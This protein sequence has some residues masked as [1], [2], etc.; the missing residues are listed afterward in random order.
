MMKKRKMVALLASVASICCVAAGM[1]FIYASAEEVEETVTA[2]TIEDVISEESGSFAMAYGAAV[3]G[4]ETNKEKNG[5]KYT[6]TMSEAHYNGLQKSVEDGVYEDVS[7]G[8]FILPASM[9]ETYA[10]RDYAFGETAKYNWAIKNAETGAWEYTAEEGKSRITNLPGTGMIYDSRFE[11]MAFYGITTNILPTNLGREML[12]VGYIAYTVNGV[13]DYVFTPVENE[14]DNVRSMAFVAQAAIEDEAENADWLYTTYVKPVEESELTYSYKK[15]YY[16]QNFAGAYILDESKTETAYASMNEIVSIEDSFVGYELDE[17]QK[18]SVTTA[19]IPAKN[20]EVVLR[21]YYKKNVQTLLVDVNEMPVLNAVALTGVDLSGQD[22]SLKLT[23]PNG[24]VIN[25]EDPTHIVTNAIPYGLYEAE[26]KVAGTVVFLAH[27]DVFDITE[28]MVWQR[29]DEYSVNDAEILQGGYTKLADVT[30]EVFQDVNVLSFDMV[31][32][33]K[34]T[35]EVGMRLRAIHSKQYYEMMS[36]YYSAITFDVAVVGDGLNIETFEDADGDGADEKTSGKWQAKNSSKTYTVDIQ[37]LL[38]NWESIN[39]VGRLSIGTTLQSQLFSTYYGTVGKQVIKVGNFGCVLAEGIELIEIEKMQLIETSESPIY[40]FLALDSEGVLDQTKAYSAVFTAPNGRVVKVNDATQVA[41]AEIPQGV[42]EVTVKCGPVDCIKVTVDIYTAADGFVWQVIDEYSVN[43]SR[44][45]K[46]HYTDTGATTFAVKDG[47]NVI[48]FTT[49]KGEDAN[50]NNSGVRIRALHSKEYYEM[51]A[52]RYETISVDVYAAIGLNVKVIGNEKASGSWQAKG[53]KTYTIPVQ[54][55]LDNWDALN[56]LTDKQTSAQ[57]GLLVGTWYGTAD[58]TVISIGNFVSGPIKEIEE[59][60]IQLLEIAEM[61]L[62]ETAATPTYNFLSLDK[63]GVLNT[64]NS[65]SAVLTAPNG[66]V[67]NIADATKVAT[68]DIPQGVYSVVV[69]TKGVECI[70]ATVDIYT[71][72]DGLVWQSIDTYSVND[73]RV[74]KHGYINIGEA[75]V[76]TI[77][78][79]NVVQFTVEKAGEGN[80]NGCGMR[81]RALHSKEYYEMM[82]ESYESI[83]IDVHVSKGMNVKPLE[84]TKAQG[85]WQNA[86][87]KTYTISVQFLL[88]NW[89]TLNNINDNLSGVSADYTTFVRAWYG[90]EGDVVSIGN[91]GSVAKQ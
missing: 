10:V 5:L 19:K 24:R 79:K 17:T 76:A 73:S 71:A 78:S 6:L 62:I 91:F 44:A 21:A 58:S 82:A 66:R 42:Y 29:M 81:I 16:M 53:W 67:V 39:G 34:N 2:C 14:A 70:K 43:D 61:Q 7:F 15:E 25:V 37:W 4:V 38:K 27:V 88:D 57:T 13:T 80:T 20:G 56:N 30:Y 40:N 22:V 83:T 26:M 68:A 48:Q 65:Y 33:V 85:S 75:T 52:V 90:A 9:N 46:H 64:A 55:L 18:D 89:D 3:R 87:W 23:A 50:T 32:G 12:G 74:W 86:G 60:E 28:G 45:W 8:I 63:E 51:M 1:N 11:A 31:T 84:N 49:V 54:L 47:K 36:A 77:D 69:K 59:E 41:T 35:T 72:A